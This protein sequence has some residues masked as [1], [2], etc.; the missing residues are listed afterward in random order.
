MMTNDAR[1]TWE[2]KSRIANAKAAFNNKIFFASKL[3]L[4]SKEHPRE[5]L[6][7]GHNLYGAEIGHF[8]K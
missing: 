8:E 4:K 6:H 7:L 1:C 5:M 2:I 3:D